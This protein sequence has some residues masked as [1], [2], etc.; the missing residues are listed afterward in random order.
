MKNKAALLALLLALCVNLGYAQS[1]TVSGVIKS[2]DGETL[3]GVAVLEKGTSNG[4]STDFDGKFTITLTSEN[5]VLVFQAIGQETK[6]VVVGSESFINVQMKESSEELDEVVITALGISKDKKALGYSVSEIGGDE[7]SKSGENNIIQ[8]LSAKAPGIQVVGSGGTPGA[9]SKILLRGNATFTGQN[10]PLIVVDGV[11]I[12]NSTTQSSPRDY[13]FNANLQGVNNSNRAIDIN[14]DDIESVTVLKGPAAAALYGARA[15]NGVIMYTTKRGRAGRKDLGVTVSQKV[16]LSQ[17]NKLPE[18]QDTYAQGTGG[19]TPSG[20]AAATYVTSDPG[21]DGVFFTADDVSLGT[22]NSW[23]PSINSLG[24]DTYDNTG[25]FFK[26]GVSTNTNVS[27]VSGTEN[28]G[29]RLSIGYLNDQGVIPTTKMERLS[30]RLTA[31][32]RLTEKIKIGGTVNYTN[33]NSVMAQNGSNVSGVMLSLL[34]APASYDLT[35]YKLSN[36]DNNNYFA[37]YDNPY[38][39]VN[40]NPF[41]SNLNRV[42]G[43]IY[44]NYNILDWLSLSYKVGADFYS[45]QRKQIFAISAR[46]ADNPGRGQVN[47]NN[48]DNASY[49]GDLIATINTNISE[50]WTFD[51]NIGHNFTSSK[52]TDV[53]SR[54]RNLAVRDFYNL[55]N[56]SDL[57]SSEYVTEIAT[58]AIFGQAEFAWDNTWFISFTGRNEWSSTFELAD[59]SFFYPSVSTSLIFTE[60]WDNRPEWFDFGKVRYSY[61]N[62]GIAP[63]AYS[64]RTL[65]STPFYTD[66]FTNGLTFPYQG[67]NGQAIYSRLFVSD[68]KPE[69]LNG[70][71]VGLNM[72]FLKRR[73]DFDIT[74]YHQTTEDALLYQPLANSSGFDEAYVNGGSILNQGFE[75]AL[76]FVPITNNNFNWRVDLNWSRNRSEVLSL[77]PGVD[78]FSI[79]EAFSSIGSFA[80]VGQPYGV[81]YGSVWERN[82]NGDILID[83]DGYPILSPETEGVGNPNPDWLGGIRNTFSYKGIQLSFFFDVRKGG[84]IWNGT[85]AR[86]N[87]IGKTQESADN[88]NSTRTVEGV[89]ASGT[90]I[91]GQDVSGQPNATPIDA[92]DYYRFVVGD[93]GGAAEEFVEEVNWVRLRDVNLS[94]RFKFDKDSKVQYLDVALNG[95]NLLLFTNYKGVDPETS[96]TGAGSNIGGFDYFNNPGTRSYTLGVSFG[97]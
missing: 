42:L 64:T 82:S 41:T 58:Q 5:P 24:I 57:Y 88:R 35:D 10:Q 95:R 76:G 19:G 50:K 97:L 83:Q 78:Q 28:T 40:E 45:D 39:T 37:A 26:T 23:G 60:F 52:N 70:H 3:P 90:V 20:D 92:I 34:R 38:Y 84:D 36:G 15:G 87:Q 62:T 94:Y 11:P 4:V 53:F 7:V 21:P 6:E 93:A 17:V 29:V 44:L 80:I 54:G 61:A 56:A 73:V 51:F 13:P 25:E 46:N 65:Y 8:S 69:R 67:Y 74:Y 18:L 33:S 14:P 32:T 48:I 31:D 55:S 89:Y 9:S 91:N 79:E 72:I 2:A 1:R 63:I 71:E 30:V 66:G 85:Y 81:F 43:N 12:D 22:A 75:V 96:L 27:V 49:Y 47:I 16:T 86:L 77:V 59:N 68:L